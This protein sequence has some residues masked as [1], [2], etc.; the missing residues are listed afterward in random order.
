[1]RVEL[2]GALAQHAWRHGQRVH[3]L[4]AAPFGTKMLLPFMSISGTIVADNR[5]TMCNPLPLDYLDCMLCVIGT[6]DGT[7]DVVLT[8]ADTEQL[9]KLVVEQLA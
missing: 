4:E 5:F 7:F 9:S 1:M 3:R 6:Q 2:V 8:R